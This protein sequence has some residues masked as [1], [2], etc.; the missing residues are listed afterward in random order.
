MEVYDTTSSQ[1]RPAARP[2]R[3]LF[4]VEQ[5][6]GTLPLVKRIVADL[7]KQY[8]KVGILEE[9]CHIRRPSVSNEEQTRLRRQY[10]IELDRLRGLAD[11]LAAVGCEPKDMRRGLVDFPANFQGRDVELC[12]RLGE[13]SIGHWHEVGA[14][15][16]GRQPLTEILTN[17]GEREAPAV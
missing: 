7:V 3:R 2:K 1:P 6:N 11:E 9:R 14:G 15:F 5:A 12:W 13:E 16:S 17:S 10:G 4:T 8:K